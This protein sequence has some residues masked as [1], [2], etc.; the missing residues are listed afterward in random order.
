MAQVN[1]IGIVG[2]GLMGHGIARV[3]AVKGYSV[4]L[5]DV[6]TEIL[7]STSDLKFVPG[8]RRSSASRSTVRLLEYALHVLRRP[9]ANLDTE[10]S[11]VSR[12]E[13]KTRGT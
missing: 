1:N 8:L 9:T 12:I 5:M 2:A 13:L 3:F 4:T 11:P 10:S 6:K 7:T